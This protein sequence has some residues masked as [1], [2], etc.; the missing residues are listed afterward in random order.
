MSN[1]IPTNQKKNVKSI[2]LGKPK[3]NDVQNLGILE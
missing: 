3:Y 2:F 1:T